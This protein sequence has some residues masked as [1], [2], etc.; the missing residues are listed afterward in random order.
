MHDHRLVVRGHRKL[1]C[2]VFS[3]SR[4]TLIWQC[5]IQREGDRL[6]CS[7]Y[8]GAHGGSQATKLSLYPFLTEIVSKLEAAAVNASSGLTI[9]SGHDTVIAPTLAGLG[10]YDRDSFLCRWPSYAS[11]IVFELYR[12]RSMTANKSSAPM[13][14]VIFNGVDVTSLIRACSD[15]IMLG[16]Q[17][18]DHLRGSSGY[19]RDVK[20]PRALCPL[21]RL[22][23]QIENMIN[24]YSSFEDACKV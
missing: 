3:S 19:G 13:I 10:V 5:F 12:P 16:E 18:L 15:S 23:A 24:P 6:Y 7:R 11:R 4:F 22:R 21:S 20:Y 2:A 8:A 14:R 1:A 9:F 17:D